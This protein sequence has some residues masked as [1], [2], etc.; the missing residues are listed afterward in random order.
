MI[1]VTRYG[2]AGTPNQGGHDG[3]TEGEALIQELEKRRD[4]NL[5]LS[6]Q[7]SGPCDYCSQASREHSSLTKSLET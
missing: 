4:F 2:T 5:A 1:F 7:V 6:K 3:E